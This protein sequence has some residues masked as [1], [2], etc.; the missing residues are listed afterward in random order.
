[1]NDEPTKLASAE[2]T[3]DGSGLD[4]VGLAVVHHAFVEPLLRTGKAPKRTEVAAAFNISVAVLDAALA[5]LEATHGAVLDPHSG[6]PWVLHPFSLT[7]TGTWVEQGGL[8]WWAPCPWCAFGIAGL[9]GGNATIH[10]W[11]GGERE[12]VAIHV[13]GGRVVEDD[14]WIHFA[15]PPRDAWNNV[16]RFCATVLPFREQ[17]DVTEWCARHGIE[18]GA[19][20]PAAQ[21]WEL[22]REWYARHADPDWHKWTGAQAAA[23]F[24]HVGLTGPFWRF[25]RSDQPF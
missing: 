6:E 5:A 8:G 13:V 3:R 9:V 24:E 21:I 11:L 17:A 20:V 1:M 25:E 18:H 12:S 16:H 15:V 10:T 22:G 2:L 4:N 7:P 19:T 23:I 14:L